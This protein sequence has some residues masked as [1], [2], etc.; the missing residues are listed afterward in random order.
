MSFSRIAA[1]IAEIANDTISGAIS[2]TSVVGRMV[3][4]AG[5]V[6]LAARSI[7]R[8]GYPRAQ[9]SIVLQDEHARTARSLPYTHPAPALRCDVACLVHFFAAASDDG[10]HAALYVSRRF[11]VSLRASYMRISPPLM[12][13]LVPILS[14]TRYRGCIS[15]LLSWR[16]QH[17]ART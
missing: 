11:F 4:H 6:I 5:R 10:A 17:G 1:E 9:H 2:P 8:V 13:R 7:T 14:V 16:T 15:L 12:R 3:A